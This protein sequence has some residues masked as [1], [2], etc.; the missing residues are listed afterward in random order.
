MKLYE[1]IEK[2]FPVI[3]KLFTAERLEEFKN[4]EISDLYLYYFGLGAWIRNNLLYSDSEENVLYG[5]FLENKIK[6]PDDMSSFII[7]L[8]HYHCYLKDSWKI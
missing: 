2:S 4:T 6:H 8:F 3:E 5:L 1:E 7:R